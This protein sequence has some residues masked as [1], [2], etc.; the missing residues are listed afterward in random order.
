[1][2]YEFISTDLGFHAISFKVIGR[3]LNSHSDALSVRWGWLEAFNEPRDF[4]QA[5]S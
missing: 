2:K 3:L 4:A 5:S 1:M